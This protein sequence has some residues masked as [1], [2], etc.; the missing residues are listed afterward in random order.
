MNNYVTPNDAGVVAESDSRSINNAVAE[1]IKNGTRKVL[2]P[3]VNER[4]G[5]ERWDLD[6]AII[7]CSDIEIV[8][9]NCYLRRTDDSFDNVFR[10]FDDDAV[11]TTIEEEQK[12]IVIRGIGNAVIDGGVTNGLTEATSSKNGLP[13]VEK[14]NVIRLHNLAGLKLLDFTILNPRW[15]AINLIYVEEALISGLNII[16]KP[17]SPNQ[18]GIDLRLGCNNIT[19]KDFHF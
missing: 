15:W 5:K 14:N 8:L 10:N 16:S 13:H 19:I 1:A 12:N 6:E 7:L 4:T 9:D 2:I 17:D 11:R 3:R 18:D